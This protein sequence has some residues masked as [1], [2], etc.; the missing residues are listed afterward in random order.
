[1]SENFAIIKQ[2]LIEFLWNIAW[3]YCCWERTG[4]QFV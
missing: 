4:W 1:M 2:Y 3:D